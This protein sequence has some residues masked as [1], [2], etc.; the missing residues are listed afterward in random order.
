MPIVAVGNVLPE[1]ENTLTR[2]GT[3]TSRAE[4]IQMRHKRFG[5]FPQAFAW[6][7]KEYKVLAVEQCRT[8]SSQWRGA[9]RHCFRVRCAEGT[10]ELYQD[11]KRGLWYLDRFEQV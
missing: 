2:E 9:E 7:E 4:Q 6:R 5:Y 11:I 8:V 1:T 3:A 10:F